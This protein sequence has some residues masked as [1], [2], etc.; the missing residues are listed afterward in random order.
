LVLVGIIEEAAKLLVP[1]AVLLTLR[2]DRAPAS[3]LLIGVAAGAGFAVLETMGYA[4][5][6]LVRSHGDLA[7][8]NSLLFVRG[9]LSPASHM[10]WTGLAAVALWRAAIEHWRPRA[11]ARFIGVFLV[12]AGLHAAWDSAATGWTFSIVALVS[13]GLLTGTVLRLEHPRASRM[14]DRG[15]S[16][17]S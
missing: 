14:V 17:P 7:V 6:A 8:V 16:L 2:R 15:P 12:V 9:L 11:M 13:L 3:G 10:A 5:V 1:V 4:L